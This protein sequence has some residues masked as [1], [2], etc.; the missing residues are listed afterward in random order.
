MKA[1][2]FCECYGC[3]YICSLCALVLS[4]PAGGAVARCSLSGAEE[5]DPSFSPSV[6]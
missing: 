4:S 5:R 1:E 3:M 6:A 2:F